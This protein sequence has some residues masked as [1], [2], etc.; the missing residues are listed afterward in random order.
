MQIYS[1]YGLHTWHSFFQ[2]GS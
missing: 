2:V 1:I